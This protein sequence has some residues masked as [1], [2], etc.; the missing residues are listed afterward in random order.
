MPINEDKVSNLQIQNSAITLGAL[1][2]VIGFWSQNSQIFTASGPFTV[3]KNVSKLKVVMAGPGGP[4]ATS[5]SGG[6]GGGGGEGIFAFV[7]CS[8]G[9][10]I[11]IA[12]SPSSTQFDTTNVTGVGTITAVGGGAGSGYAP[13]GGG[14]SSH[15]NPITIFSFPG[16]PGTPGNSS[17]NISGSGGSALFFGGGAPGE[18]GPGNGQSGYGYGAGGAG[19]AGAGHGAGSGNTGVVIIFW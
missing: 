14:I 2:E 1:G 5:G 3:P 19:G 16:T 7:P 12:I 9:M 13:G 6:G 11:N 10:Q 15:E 18:G 17:A 4:G 8:E